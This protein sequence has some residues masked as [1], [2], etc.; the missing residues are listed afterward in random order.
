[1]TEAQPEVWG[2]LKLIWSRIPFLYTVVSL[3]AWAVV[4]SSLEREEE[5]KDL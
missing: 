2:D 3:P 1:M 4:S 5:E